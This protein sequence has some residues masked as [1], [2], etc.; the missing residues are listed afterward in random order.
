MTKCKCES[1]TFKSDYT[2]Q[3]NFKLENGIL[4]AVDETDIGGSGVFECS[5]CG[6]EYLPK[7]FKE[8]I[9]L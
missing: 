1:T 2:T 6:K 8:I 9:N 7:D 3:V 4:T 5:E